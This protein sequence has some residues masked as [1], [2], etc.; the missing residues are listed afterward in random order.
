MST[1]PCS[2]CG[3]VSILTLIGTV[4]ARMIGFRSTKVNAERQIEAQSEQLDRTL[5]ER[6]DQLEHTC[7]E[8]GTRS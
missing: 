2:V 8:Q 1:Q 5:A 7:A 4:I 6:S 3:G